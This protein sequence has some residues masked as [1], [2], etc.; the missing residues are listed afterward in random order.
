VGNVIEL[1][2]KRKCTCE[3]KRLSTAVMLSR[4]DPEAFQNH[5]S[6]TLGMVLANLETLREYM[7]ILATAVMKL[8]GKPLTPE[9]NEQIAADLGFDLD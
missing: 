3:A 2:S 8:Q 4:L 1:A 7:V 9:E 6:L 5:A